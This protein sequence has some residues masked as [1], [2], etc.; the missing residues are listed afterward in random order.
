MR[1]SARRRGRCHPRGTPTSRVVVVTVGTRA[2][3]TTDAN[4][5][6]APVSPTW[7]PRHFEPRILPT[8]ICR[9]MRDRGTRAWD[10]PFIL[11]GTDVV[12][13]RRHRARRRRPRARRL[14]NPRSTARVAP[15]AVCNW[16]R[17]FTRARGVRHTPWVM[18]HEKLYDTVA[19]PRRQSLLDGIFIYSKLPATPHVSRRARSSAP[20][21]PLLRTAPRRHPR[22]QARRSPRCDAPTR[23]TPRRSGV[24]RRQQ[25]YQ[26]HAR[27]FHS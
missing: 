16:P 18:T 19:W 8:D 7:T 15:R 9:G 1:V 20:T 12:H 3:A 22:E 10:S 2:G 6:D 26:H 23:D 13:D 4:D 24:S 11:Y 17:P 14:A 27:P 5:R 21:L 25:P